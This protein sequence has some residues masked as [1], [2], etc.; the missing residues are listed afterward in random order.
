MLLT[1]IY[2][3]KVTRYA[4]HLPN[5]YKPGQRRFDG[6]F[7]S[8]TPLR[9]IST[10]LVN[11]SNGRKCRRT[12]LSSNSLCSGTRETTSV[13]SH[14]RNPCT[15]NSSSCGTASPVLKKKSY[16]VTLRSAACKQA[17]TTKRSYSQKLLNAYGF[18][19]TECMA[20]C[21]S[22]FGGGSA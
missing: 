14:G 7:P 18:P 12:Y 1:R 19:V 10:P 21:K 16:A 8:S 11:P 15:A 22:L 20:R 17:Y 3:R 13:K 5:P 4:H 9:A 6:R 2:F